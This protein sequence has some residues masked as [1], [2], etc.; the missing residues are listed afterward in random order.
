MPG[1]GAPGAGDRK[2]TSHPYHRSL[3]PVAGWSH[4]G[5]SAVA[6]V[7]LTEITPVVTADELVDS[8]VPPPRFADV[9][10]TTYRPDPGEPSQRAAVHALETFAARVAEPPRR[11]LFRKSAPVSAGGYYL[12]GGF[13]VG[14]T[15]LLASLWHAVPWPKTYGTFVEYTHLVGALGFAETVRRLADRRLVAVDEFELDDPGD[16]MLMTRLLGELADSNTLFF[17]RTPAAY[18]LRHV[19]KGRRPRR[20]SLHSGGV[21]I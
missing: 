17:C 14:K 1:T 18:C 16:T 20:L 2:L 9:R 8:L 5:W 19:Q 10:F 13:G 21:D 15:H 3:W 12:D 4:L 6:V 7:H 11:G